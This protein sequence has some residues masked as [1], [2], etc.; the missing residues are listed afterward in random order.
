V[1]AVALPAD[2]WAALARRRVG[3]TAPVASY[4]ATLSRNP[5]IRRQQLI[6]DPPEPIR[7]STSVEYEADKV[8]LV[9]F[10]YG[11]GYGPLAVDERPVQGYV[12]VEAAT[13]RFFQD[14]DE[15]LTDPAGRE[16]GYAQVLYSLTGQAGQIAPDGVVLDEDY[17]LGDIGEGVDTH[18][19]FFEEVEGAQLGPATYHVYADDGTRAP[20]ADFL[21]GLDEA[22]G[23][24]TV[25]AAD[26]GDATVT[27]PEPSSL[28][29]FS[30][31]AL[32]LLSRPRRRGC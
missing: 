5:T 15:F 8:N 26:I 32:G 11:P 25:P 12:E 18:Q 10:A 21:V 20:S 2:T 29:L 1:A 22:G 24:F 27:A 16:T 19:F 4:S 31:A 9:G 6:C 7:G 3:G 23:Q 30:L 17:G 13:E 14:I 28:A